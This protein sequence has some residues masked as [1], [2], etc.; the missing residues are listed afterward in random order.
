MSREEGRASRATRTSRAALRFVACALSALFLAAQLGSAAHFLAVR[1]G[2]CPEHGELVHLE[3]GEGATHVSAVEAAL[4]A[5]AIAAADADAG[6][7]LD[8]AGAR[9]KVEADEH[10]PTAA[11]PRREE[12]A[13]AAVAAGVAP[14]PHRAVVRTSRGQVEAGARS[15]EL[16]RLAPKSS[17][18]ARA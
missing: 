2:V 3:P 12:H 14:P 17:P 6:P 4:G 5:R 1:H 9:A 10:C 18:P 16:L 7:G 8:R 13:L 15:L 11:A